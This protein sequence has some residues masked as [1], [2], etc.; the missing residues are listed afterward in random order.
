[1]LK[2]LKKANIGVSIVISGPME[3]AKQCC[4]KA[5]LSRHTVNYSLGINGRTELLPTEEVLEISTMCGH[6]MVAFSLVEHMVGQIKKGTTS[7]EKAA[8]KLAAQ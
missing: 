6:G 2:E 3:T 5:G 7:I 4:R 8:E 1:M